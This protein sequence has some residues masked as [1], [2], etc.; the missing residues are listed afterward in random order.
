[1]QIG[2]E[3]LQDSIDPFEEGREYDDSRYSSRDY[4]S[5]GVA[6]QMEGEAIDLTPSLDFHL[7]NHTNNSLDEITVEL[8]SGEDISTFSQIRASFA[9]GK[10]ISMK[11]PTNVI[12]NSVYATVI[13]PSGKYRERHAVPIYNCNEQ[14]DE[15]CNKIVVVID[16]P[17]LQELIK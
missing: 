7:V 17:R 6:A 13:G 11:L 16:G 2:E 15:E 3:T 9:Q 10:K 5:A 4:D 8:G 14:S 12:S 1:V